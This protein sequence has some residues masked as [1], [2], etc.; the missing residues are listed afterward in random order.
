MKNILKLLFVL[1]L[2]LSG[3]LVVPVANAQSLDIESLKI[4]LD[5]FTPSKE[6]LAALQSVA[7]DGDVSVLREA[8]VQALV[9]DG[10][11]AKLIMMS[12]MATNM[13]AGLEVFQDVMTDY[14]ATQ[15]DQ[16]NSVLSSIVSGAVEAS[17]AIGNDPDD[18][19]NVIETIVAASGEVIA[20]SDNV[21]GD[22]LEAVVGSVV[23]VLLENNK[24]NV[25]G[26]VELVELVAGSAIKGA[27]AAGGNSPSEL[28]GLIN[29]SMA[30]IIN[31]A[32]DLA[33]STDLNVDQMVD[34]VNDA[35]QSGIISSLGQSNEL[36]QI[37]VSSAAA[38]IETAVTANEFETASSEPDA[39]VDGEDSVSPN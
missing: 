18:N 23:T 1:C 8:L 22:S 10:E 35:A 39:E 14:V 3:P 29:A 7:N 2:F 24:D 4:K 13:S 38:S 36:T 19:A 31:T 37:L 25:D 17:L 9:A 34:A 33:G 15:P 5:G 12:V 6:L 27:I 26:S 28:S 21:S 11:N 32:M 20:S 30:G 16:I